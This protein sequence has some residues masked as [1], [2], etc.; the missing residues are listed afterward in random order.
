MV[1]V[2]T[3]A[4]LPVEV[5]D[6]IAEEAG[7]PLGRMEAP[8]VELALRQL[9]PTASLPKALFIDVVRLAF[10]KVVWLQRY[11]EMAAMYSYSS[12]SVEDAVQKDYRLRQFCIWA[13]KEVEKD[14][15]KASK[16]NQPGPGNR[17]VQGVLVWPGLRPGH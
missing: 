14:D 1:A 11:L 16:A 3:Y 15:C 9:G 2:V 8:L 7:L 10:A 12:S 6:A 13:L 17:W 5:L 4:S